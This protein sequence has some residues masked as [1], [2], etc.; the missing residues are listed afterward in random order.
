MGYRKESINPRISTMRIDN[1]VNSS[2]VIP[3]FVKI[4]VEGF[5]YEVLEGI[6]E[7]LDK[8]R[9]KIIMETHS[10]ALRKK[11]DEF[12]VE[13]EYEQWYEG[14]ATKGLGWMDEVVNLFYGDATMQREA[15]K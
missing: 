5:E 12:L 10:K 1:F 8:Y 7:T 9:P 13:H 11:C 4:D 3:D 6:V 2:S 14:R 15:L